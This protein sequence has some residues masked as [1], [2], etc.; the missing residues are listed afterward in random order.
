MDSR[1]FDIQKFLEHCFKEKKYIEPASRA[2]ITKERIFDA[3][4]T[5]S[6]E[7]IVKVG[8]GTGELLSNIA[9]HSKGT[10]V[11]V[12]PSLSN[13]RKYIKEQGESKS[14][15]FIAGDLNVLPVDYYRAD[16]VI[17]VDNLS[18]IESGTA[19]D[20]FRRILQFEAILFISTP[21]LADGDE[22]GALDDYMRILFPLHNEYYMADELKTVLEH[23]EFSF[24]KSGLNEFK[25][26][27]A[28]AA[29]FFCSVYD[30][31][32]TAAKDFIGKHKDVFEQSYKLNA[33]DYA[34]SYYSGLFRRI[35]PDYA[36][37]KY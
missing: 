34:V 8:L 16:M 6:P 2:E 25:E 3:I 35:K 29:D 13:I 31:D 20:E 21:V 33:E 9:G 19:I 18:F 11:V 22:E 10:I 27:S 26:P 28:A 15:R 30:S 4:D 7:V 37:E 36:Y 24:V 32:L 14:L 17:T 5:Y 12:E 1:A 23:K